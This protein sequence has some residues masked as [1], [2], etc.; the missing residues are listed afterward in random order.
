MSKTLQK[1]RNKIFGKL[2]TIVQGQPEATL[3]LNRMVCVE[4]PDID[5]DFGSAEVH[6]NTLRWDEEKETLLAEGEHL[7]V[8][9]GC[10]LGEAEPV[11]VEGLDA[12]EVD[13]LFEEAQRSIRP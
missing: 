7:D 2:K 5:T 11:D 3:K 6:I 9:D 12:V 1:A 13:S 4:D 10:P 8:E